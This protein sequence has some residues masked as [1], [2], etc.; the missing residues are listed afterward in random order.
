MKHDDFRIFKAKQT[1]EKKRLPCSA[2][3]GV[4]H[5]PV[6]EEGKLTLVE[7]LLQH[8]LH[9]VLDVGRPARQ[10]VRLSLALLPVLRYVLASRR[11]LV[12]VLEYLHADVL[13]V[14][15]D[16]ALL[17]GY[18]GVMQQLLQVLLGDAVLVQQEEHDETQLVLDLD[19]GVEQQRHD[20][21]HVVL[22]L[23]A[24]RVAAHRQVLLD[25]AQL[26]D[27]GRE[28]LHAVLGQVE[29]KRIGAQLLLILRHLLQHLTQVLHG[30]LVGVGR[31][32]AVGE[33]L[34]LLGHVL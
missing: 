21:L 5:G 6:G 15:H 16:L 31:L 17:L 2:E 22:D 9:Y 13:Q 33:V 3:V 12:G 32:L 26:L 27:L 14:E 7:L 30:R 34:Q 18:H 29:V 20:V 24:L 28:H 11:G 10:L 1:I 8:V 19:L 23:L 4:V 25:L